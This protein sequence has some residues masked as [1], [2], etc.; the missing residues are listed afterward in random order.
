MAHELPM[1]LY[2]IEIITISQKAMSPLTSHIKELSI[3][4]LHS[5]LRPTVLTGLFGVPAWLKS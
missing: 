5:F 1:T 2:I 4:I 3:K